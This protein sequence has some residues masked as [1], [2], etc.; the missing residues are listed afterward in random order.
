MKITVWRE[1]VRYIL[2]LHLLW[3]HTL[4]YL[5][6]TVYLNGNGHLFMPVVMYRLQII[7]WLS[8]HAPLEYTSQCLLVDNVYYTAQL[9]V[10]LFHQ[11]RGHKKLSQV[12]ICWYCSAS[13]E[14]PGIRWPGWNM[15]STIKSWGAALPPSTSVTSF[16]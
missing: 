12:H 14:P 16:Q 6:C 15:R 8:I 11:D 9:R 2:A 4:Q 13:G 10:I 3:L 7:G 5:C 1:R